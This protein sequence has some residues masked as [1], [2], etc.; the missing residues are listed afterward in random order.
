MQPVDAVPAV[1]DPGTGQEDII[2]RV[3][4]QG[5][6]RGGNQRA[7]VAPEHPL[8]IDV[9][10]VA[11]I[12]GDVAGAV[13]EVVVVVHDGDDAVAAP[14]ADLASPPVRQRAGG[15]IEGELEGVRA[16]RRVGEVPDGQVTGELPGGKVSRQSGLLAK[17]SDGVPE[18]PSP[19]ASPL[20][21][22][23]RLSSGDVAKSGPCGTHRGP[24]GR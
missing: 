18:T 22:V 20:S 14:P 3:R 5:P 4:G 23:R 6:Q 9:A 19:G 7:G 2:G 24:G 11:G 13:A 15:A 21:G 12:T 8:V 1:D 16:G 10:G 17:S